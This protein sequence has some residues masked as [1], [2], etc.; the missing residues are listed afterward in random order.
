[1]DAT[2][3][4]AATAAVCDECSE[5]LGTH[6][7]HLGVSLIVCVTCAEKARVSLTNVLA[8]FK[9]RLRSRA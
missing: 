4:T 5:P 1:M 8:A 6:A 7:V 3:R 9:R 2:I